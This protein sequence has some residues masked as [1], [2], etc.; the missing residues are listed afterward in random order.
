MAGRPPARL[1]RRKADACHS[2]EMVAAVA[3]HSGAVKR[4][5]NASREWAESPAFPHLREIAQA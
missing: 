2:S 5:V 3:P 4:E 1:R